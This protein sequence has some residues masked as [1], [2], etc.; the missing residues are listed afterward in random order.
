MPITNDMESHSHRRRRKSTQPSAM[1]LHPYPTC[2]LYLTF[3]PPPL[4]PV[5][6]TPKSPPRATRGVVIDGTAASASSSTFLDGRKFSGGAASASPPIAMSATMRD[7]SRDLK[8]INMPAERE[9][10]RSSGP[11]FYSNLRDVRKVPHIPQMTGSPRGRRSPRSPLRADAGISK[12]HSPRT[13][14]ARYPPPRSSSYTEAA[15]QSRLQHQAEIRRRRELYEECEKLL[16]SGRYT[17]A[18]LMRHRLIMQL[19]DEERELMFFQHEQRIR[20]TECR[21]AAPRRGEKKSR[22]TVM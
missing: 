5:P 7:I 21:C 6:T 3:P 20:R 22:C 15:R 4:K 10:R 9:R 18:Q 11:R 14:R 16:D 8:S 17:H 13:I 19:A 12:G 1:C 2:Q